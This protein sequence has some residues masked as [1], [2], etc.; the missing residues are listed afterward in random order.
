MI[1]ALVGGYLVAG[2][3]ALGALFANSAPVVIEVPGPPTPAPITVVERAS[4]P[5]SA[6][7]SASASAV[8]GPQIGAAIPQSPAL[9]DGFLASGITKTDTSLT[10][11][12]GELRNGQTLSGRF[13]FTLD[14]N[15][16]TV[17]YVCGTAS[18]TS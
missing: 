13:C 14:A 18:S 8:E 10:L 17:E 15:L 9:Y 12:T 7:A 11:S 3:I 5:A 16:P 4:S 2:L 1:F 6:S